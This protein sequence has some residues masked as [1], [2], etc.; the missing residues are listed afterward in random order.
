[1]SESLLC[2]SEPKWYATGEAAVQLIADFGGDCDVAAAVAAAADAMGMDSPP[3]FLLET[4]KYEQ[5]VQTISDEYQPICIC[6]GGRPR[7]D[8]KFRLYL[9]SLPK[10]TA[11]AKSKSIHLN[12]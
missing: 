7:E 1:M 6:E 11:A 4:V 2:S 12:A 5:W 9:I 10:Q 8:D 3:K